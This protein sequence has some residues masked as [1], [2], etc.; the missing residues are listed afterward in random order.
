MKENLKQLLESGDQLSDFR[1]AS[2]YWVSP[3]GKQILGQ[4]VGATHADIAEEELVRLGEKAGAYTVE[5]LYQQMFSRGYVRVKE[6]FSTVFAD[7]M[8]GQV[9]TTAQRRALLL[10]AYDSDKD[11]LSSR[12]RQIE[13]IVSKVLGR[14]S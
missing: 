9:L 12:G 10:R 14:H 4:R 2:Q 13:S 1:S 6:D 11:L 8:P 3:S 7:T 5:E